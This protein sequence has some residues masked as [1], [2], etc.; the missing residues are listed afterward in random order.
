MRIVDLSIKRPVFITV[1]FIALLIVGILSYGGLNLNDMPQADIPMVSVTA[2]DRGV[3]P[4]QMEAKIAK[5]LEEA[6][7]EISGV[8]HITTNISEGFCSLIIEFELEKSPDIASQE[9]QNKI[10]A[11]RKDLPDEM[12][13]PIVS[14]RDL[15][16]MPILSLAVTGD[17]DSRALS[18]LVD[19]VITKRFYTV[20]GVGAVEVYGEEEREI[21]IKA[22]L[23]KLAAYGLAP[24]EMVAGVMSGNL[25]KPGGA[26]EDGGREFSLRTDNT[27]R[28]VADFYGI[29]VGNRSG[30]NI[31]IR[32]VATVSDG[33]KEMENLSFYDGKPAVG[34]DVSKQSGANTVT[35][36]DNLKAE[37]Q[38]LSQVL[39]DS[40]KIE[41]VRDNSESIRDSV[42]EVVKTIIEGCILAV[43][44]VFLFLGEWETT[45]ISAISLPV[46]IITTF[47]AM[48]VMDFSLNTMSLMALSLAVGLLIDDA[49]VVIENIVRHLR[50]GKTPLQAAKD[51][52]S[53]IGLAVLATTLAVVAVFIPIGLVSGIIGKFFIEFGLTVAFSMLV[54]LFVSFT[55]VPMLSSRLLRQEKQAHPGVVAVLLERF[56]GVFDSIAEK[57]GTLMGKVLR[58][59]WK[60]LFVLMAVFVLSLSMVPKLGFAFI[61][62]T[63]NGE[64][65]I[66][67]NLDSGLTLA[68]RGSKAHEI[69][70]VLQKNPN[71][72][73]LYTTVG[74]D[75]AS[76]FVKLNDKSEREE[77]SREIAEL[78][79]K[80]I[81]KIAGVESQIMPGSLGPV[82]GSDV[83]FIIQGEDMD[84]IRAVA[85]TAKKT[86]EADPH[87]RDVTMNDKT[88]KLETRLVIDRDMAT[89]LGIDVAMASETLKALYDGIDAGK[90]DWNGD[91]YNIRMSAEDS[92]KQNMDSLEGIFVSGSQGQQVSLA[93]ITDK[94]IS[95]SESTIHRY[96]RMQ[97]IEISANVHGAATGDYLNTYMAKL[98]A[99]AAETPGIYIRTGGQSE[100]M[101]EGMG[102]LVM[103]LLMGIMF[104]YMIMAMQFE[105]FL[106][107]IAIMFALPMALIGAVLGLFVAGSEL[108]IMSLIG[109]ILLMGLVAKNGILLVDF[110]RQKLAE[111]LPMTAALIEAGRVRLRP[112]LMTTLA[113][114]FG[115][116]PIATATGAGTEMRAPM[117]HA[118]IGGLISS[119]ILT[120]FVVPVVYSLLR[121][122][123]DWAVKRLKK[124]S[125]DSSQTVP[126]N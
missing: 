78:F 45:L 85:Q 16:A 88:G 34:I 9:V 15:T 90:F 121:D 12:D 76:L 103:S 95:T 28:T 1:I 81:R 73:H 104:M 67:A 58:H 123:K 97:Q 99:V 60:T 80:E 38:R 120:L 56:N 92:E 66:T 98:K 25:D 43:I 118:V 79:R 24:A 11:I 40:V 49:I 82:S 64:I 55:L 69:E 52:S 117:G 109:I 87:S 105:S 36:A 89:D 42:H 31:L 107:P 44:I 63:D 112:I 7:G 84:Q 21:Q 68:A 46:S 124:P 70:A 110:A 5:K 93:S 96:D 22:D 54:S 77:S 47:I 13:E 50:M 3:A 125:G 108:S 20:P 41:I 101:Q 29:A 2:S 32:D 48:K 83:S 100:S 39:P 18:K 116:I 114:I 19:D 106:E 115:M 4:D 111:G 61:P 8:K 71:V 57:Y 94:V 35:V 65:N 122:M 119:T 62:S 72:R 53:E 59:R 126:E 17:I 26:V 91:R 75:S 14:K 86:L 27:V 113:M 74:S 37:L 30:H 23:G 102:N 10:A 51:G 33:V 6:V